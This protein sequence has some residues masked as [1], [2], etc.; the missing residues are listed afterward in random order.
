VVSENKVLVTGGTGYIGSCLIPRLLEKGCFVRVLVRDPKQLAGRDWIS[1]VDLVKGD[2]MSDSALNQAMAGITTAY[3]LVHQMS[4]GPGYQAKEIQAAEKFSTAAGRHALEHIIYLGGL[5]DPDKNIGEHLRSRIQTG[6]TLRL[7]KV[8]VTEFRA[9][10]IIGAG[11]ISFELIRYLTE[12]LPILLAPEWAGNLSQPVA[13]QDVLDYLLS[14]M[15]FPGCR[16]KTYEIG[17]KNVLTYAEVMQTY[18][19]IRGLKR[20]LFSIHGL[21]V[22]L[23]AWMAGRLTPVPAEVA[24]PLLGGMCTDS[25]VIIDSASQDFPHIKP[26]DYETS[27]RVALERLSPDGVEMEF[28]ERQDSFHLKKE[29]FF[30]EGHSI[31]LPCRPQVI[32]R[33]IN[34]L[35]GKKGWLALNGLWKFRGFVDRLIGGPGM[36]GRSEQTYLEEGSVVDFYRVDLL[37]EDRLVRLK[38]ELKAPGVGWMEWRIEPRNGDSVN[39]VQIAYFAPR[40]FSGYFYWYFLLPFHRLVFLRLLKAVDR[41]VKSHNLS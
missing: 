28:D 32:Y 3:Y 12:Q 23:M 39:L 11:S 25:V 34:E 33:V 10:L 37:E 41:K 17:G 16:G 31:V 36:R 21:P 20:R 6:E 14:A 4:S 26:M 38:A 24:G 35:G 27:V 15:E 5:A 22:N 19:F 18:A 2:L 7:G 9:S 8:P 1:K 29:G 30:I 40:G 13:V